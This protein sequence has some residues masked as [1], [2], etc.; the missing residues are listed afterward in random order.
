MHTH[1]TL[2]GQIT[3]LTNDNRMKEVAFAVK[4]P[5]TILLI[6]LIYQQYPHTPK[7]GRMPIEGAPPMTTAHQ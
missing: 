7:T 6:I 2:S 3:L 4:A 5:T 1:N